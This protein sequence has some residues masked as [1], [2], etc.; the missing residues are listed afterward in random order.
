MAAQPRVEA[1]QQLWDET[2]SRL[3]NLSSATV[4]HNADLQNRVA[5]LE[6]ELSVWKQA[7]SVAL[8][9]SER[10]A[11]AHNVQVAALNRQISNLDCFRGTQNPLILCIVNGDEKIFAKDLIIQGLHGG[12][13]A[14]QQL[15]KAI[16]EYLS[17]EELH[18]F[19]RLSF[20][21]TIYIN[22][23]EILNK[24]VSY[25]FCT[26][27][28]LDAFF[29]GFSSASPRFLVVDTGYGSDGVTTKITEYLQTYTRFSQTLR[30]FFATYELT[31]YIPLFDE[32]EQEQVLGKIIRLYTPGDRDADKPSISLPRLQLDDL[33][34]TE[35][36]PRTS[37]S[38]SPHVVGLNGSVD[39]QSP[40][41]IDP[42]LP[43]H[44]QNPPPCNEFYLMTCSKGPGTCKYSHDYILTPEQLEMLA[45][46]A[47]KA[48]CNWLK[49]GTCI[50]CKK[51]M[52]GLTITGVPCP[53]GEKCCWG[54][55]CP[56][57]P[58]CFHLSKGKCW[59]K[60]EAM[61]PPLAAEST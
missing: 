3:I 15:T 43:L 53:H 37:H 51:K 5:E 58:K 29:T 35:Q 41:N 17:K 7:H 56:N 61:H 48:P 42:N 32:L 2:L 38:D 11:K 28:Q 4:R 16:A 1:S 21:I 19:G 24:L 30:I 45:I 14:A 12:K 50:F 36:V 31:R 54:H 26:A 13:T 25:E 27:E 33:F 55:V 6:M 9:V 39:A 34:V 23:L 22:K 52:E 60:G 40:R 47:K 46:N 44:K 57:G 10:E 8:E 49:N 59:F 18:I 20:W